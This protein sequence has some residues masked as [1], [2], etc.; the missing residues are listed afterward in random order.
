MWSDFFF[1]AFFF[2]LTHIY[3][4]CIKGRIN[5]AILFRDNLEE[6]HNDEII[7]IQFHKL[8]CSSPKADLKDCLKKI[9]TKEH[10]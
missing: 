8:T 9:K 3:I 7:R 1:Y 2:F 4:W 10:P 5:F 6:S